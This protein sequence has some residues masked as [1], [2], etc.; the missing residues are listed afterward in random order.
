M[1]IA[2]FNNK[3][4]AYV[5]T[6]M[7]FALGAAFGRL[8]IRLFEEN[9]RASTRVGWFT[10]QCSCGAGA[11]IAAQEILTTFFACRP[12]GPSKTSNETRSPS[13]SVRKPSAM[14]EAW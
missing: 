14:I 8:P 11:Q 5:N 12:F 4:I 1:V 7:T 9:P 6:G 10:H 3:L 13:D 2:H